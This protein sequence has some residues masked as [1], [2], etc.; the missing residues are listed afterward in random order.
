[1][2]TVHLVPAGADTA[3]GLSPGDYLLRPAGDGLYEI[4]A[5]QEA[6]TWLGT[7]AGS[8]LPPL[9]PVSDDQPP[10]DPQS[11]DQQSLLT[12]VEGVAAAEH[13]RGG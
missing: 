8:L 4:G 9:P 1:M 5:Q 7:V 6:C 13:L 3:P 11:L 12:A 2:P 10:P